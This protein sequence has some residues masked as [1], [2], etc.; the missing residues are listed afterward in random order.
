MIEYILE[1]ISIFRAKK[2]CRVAISDVEV[3]F[4]VTDGF[5]GGINFTKTE[6]VDG[7]A[8]KETVT[9]HSGMVTFLG[10]GPV[11]ITVAMTAG[12]GISDDEI[13]DGFQVLFFTLIQ[14]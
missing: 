9:V 14:E 5:L 6:T 4:T 8:A 11:E 10:F 3:T 1:S 13:V 12:E 7:I 2:Y